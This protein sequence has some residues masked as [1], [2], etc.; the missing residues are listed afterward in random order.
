[1]KEVFAMG[2]AIKVAGG[3]EVFGMEVL[4][5]IIPIF[6]TPPA[7]RALYGS[8]T[9][10]PAPL[11]PRAVANSGNPNVGFRMA[12]A[13]ALAVGEGPNGIPRNPVAAA[14]DSGF[15]DL[16]YLLYPEAAEA[17][18]LALLRELVHNWAQ[19]ERELWVSNPRP[20]P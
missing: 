20:N 16:V 1:M 14:E 17:V 13:L 19:L 12:L 5:Q 10:A 15:W 8:S 18:G 7:Q 3:D 11:S 4:P 9:P 2:Q 6:T